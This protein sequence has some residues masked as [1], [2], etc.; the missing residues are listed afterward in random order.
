MLNDN[1]RYASI[2]VADKSVKGCNA[3]WKD[4]HMGRRPFADGLKRFI[5]AQKG[6]VTIALNGSWGR[7][8]T[9]LLQRLVEDLKQDFQSDAQYAAP[10][11]VYHNSWECDYIDN[12]LLPIITLIAESLS[13]DTK[14]LSKKQIENLL[15][16]AAKFGISIADSFLG[17]RIATFIKA[18]KDVVRKIEDV[19]DTISHEDEEFAKEFLDELT[20]KTKATETLKELLGKC[21]ENVKAKTNAPLVIVIDE[22]DRC[23]PSYAVET[24]E[25]IK[26]CFCVPNIVFVL[27]IDYKQL[28]AAIK[29]AY[30][31]EDMDNYL[32]RFINLTIPLPLPSPDE[33]VRTLV[34][35]HKIDSAVNRGVC[36][37]ATP[38]DESFKSRFAWSVVEM[39][40]I[41]I[42]HADLTPREIEDV[43]CR[44]LMVGLSVDYP[45]FTDYF[46]LATLAILQVKNP[47][48]FIRYSTGNLK[49]CN[50]VKNYFD[51][52]RHPPI[53]NKDPDPFYAF[54]KI[55]ELS[56]KRDARSVREVCAKALQETAMADNMLLEHGGVPKSPTTLGSIMMKAI[57]YDHSTLGHCE[58]NLQWTFRSRVE[59]ICE[60]L[61]F[62]YPDFD[63]GWRKLND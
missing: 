10:V 31:Y 47:D 6:P 20:S 38:A 14:V 15:F 62:N 30:G 41:L 53:D 8:K 59:V 42:T 57:E 39:L 21:A 9:F 22:L 23:R 34:H 37:I 13:S 48:L 2:E 55:I 4:D 19:V 43:V 50:E 58:G 44:Y 3:L 52:Y 54:S 5:L 26:H 7:G 63:K 27:G 16:E 1:V 11:A 35:E 18:G 24:L 17:G 49:D 29:G 61:Q 60:I 45:N 28:S 25:R 40:C 51:N 33:F 36:H 32:R 12:P 56:T 46:L